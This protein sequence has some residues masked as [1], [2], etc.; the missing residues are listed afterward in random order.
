MP[1]PSSADTVELD[2]QLIFDEPN[3]AE[4]STT[5]WSG[6]MEFDLNAERRKIYEEITTSRS[7]NMGQLFFDCGGSRTGKPYLWKALVARLRPQFLLSHW[8]AGMASLLLLGRRTALSIFMIPLDIKKFSTCMIKRKSNLAK[9]TQRATLVIYDDAP[10]TLRNAFHVVNR[11]WIKPLA[12]PKLARA[13]LGGK[14]C[15][16][17]LVLGSK[18]LWTIIMKARRLYRKI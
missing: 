3:Y 15:W 9:L 12:N 1:V 8:T 2:D 4:D 11:T 6:T 13:P 18:L 14:T 7:S 5:H 10:M 17:S 16:S